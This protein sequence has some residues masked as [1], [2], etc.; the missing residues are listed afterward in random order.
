MTQRSRKSRA[1]IGHPNRRR[2][3]PAPA[4]LRDMLGGSNLV[5]D[6]GKFV[7]MF[8]FIA[9]FQA[10]YFVLWLVGDIKYRTKL[11]RKI[12]RI[13][14]RGVYELVLTPQQCDLAEAAKQNGISQEM[15]QSGP[16]VGASGGEEEEPV[17]S[18]EVDVRPERRWSLPSF[19]FRGRVCGHV[20]Q[21]WMA[22]SSLVRGACGWFI[23][24]RR[25]RQNSF[26]NAQQTI[27]T[28]TPKRPARPQAKLRP[29]IEAQPLPIGS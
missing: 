18:E 20:W 25:G 3:G 16:S 15:R 5:W 11:V 22:V 13:C 9:V 19:G 14:Q 2:P 26:T 8:H 28:P 24:D 10:L 21:A 27:G 4:G 1:L 17:M 6:T 7:L 23:D 29:K 12:K